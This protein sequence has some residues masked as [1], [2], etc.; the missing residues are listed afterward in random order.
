MNQQTG[1]RF[2]TDT[3]V[4]LS[5]LPASSKDMKKKLNITI[6]EVA[7]GAPVL[8]FGECS[9]TSDRG[10]RRAFRWVFVVAKILHVI[11]RADFLAS[12]FFLYT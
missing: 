5:V 7:N 6:L 2:L 10:L 3:G 11:I 12:L 1:L 8:T 9:M 4:K